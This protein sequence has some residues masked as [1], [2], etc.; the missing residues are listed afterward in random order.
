MNSLGAAER[1]GF[2]VASNTDLTCHL[3]YLMAWG[4]CIALIQLCMLIIPFPPRHSSKEAFA[5]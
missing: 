5:T 2:G 3:L 1:R 4:H